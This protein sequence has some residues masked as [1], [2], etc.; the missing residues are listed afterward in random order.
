MFS[1]RQAGRLKI[2]GQAEEEL[3]FVAG[4]PREVGVRGQ[5]GKN[6]H[7]VCLSGRFFPLI[8]PRQELLTNY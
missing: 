5:S 1:N 6:P 4:P 8:E 3:V 7:P 2:P